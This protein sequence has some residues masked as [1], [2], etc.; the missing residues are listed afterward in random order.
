MRIISGKYRGKVLASFEGKDVRPTIDRVKE[1]IF[2]VIQFDIQGSR[3]VD[4]FSG[5][6]SL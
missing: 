5:T 4:L 2:N 1:S 3:F 6:G